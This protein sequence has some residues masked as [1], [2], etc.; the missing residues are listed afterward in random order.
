M[1]DPPSAATTAVVLAR[2]LARGGEGELD[3]GGTH[4]L[5][6]REPAYNSP[7][8]RQQPPVSVPRTGNGVPDPRS[9]RG[10]R[11]RRRDRARRAV[12]ARV[13]GDAGVACQSAR[14]RG[15]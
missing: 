13:A 2:R 4:W 6:I 7:A 10:T 15:A 12:T 5:S 14:A 8:I 11:R 3:Q 1:H 9:A